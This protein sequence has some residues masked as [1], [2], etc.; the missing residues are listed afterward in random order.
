MEKARI[1]IVMG[2]ENDREVM[3][4]G[5]ALLNE[6]GVLF[7]LEVSSAHRH[8][9]RTAAFAKNA[10]KEGVEVIIAAAG[11]AAHLPGV[12]AAYTTLPVI[13]I[14]LKG[15]TL[16]GIDA[17]LSIVQMPKGVPVATVGIDAARNACILACQILAIKYPRLRQRLDALR[18]K[19]KMDVEEKG[20]RVSRQSSA[21]S[22]QKRRTRKS[23]V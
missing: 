11:M 20:A 5:F 14:P 23:K 15:K 22:G 10:R 17:L 13:G 9:E 12:I 21:I 7:R 8:P 16:P 19:M 18:E 1:L 2:S 6:L 4:D 3:E